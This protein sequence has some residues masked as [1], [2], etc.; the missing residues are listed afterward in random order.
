MLTSWTIM[1]IIRQ[2]W[3]E[4]LDSLA[5]S[6]SFINF[7]TNQNTSRLQHL[8]RAIANA[9]LCTR[10]KAGPYDEFFLSHM[11]KFFFNGFLST[12]NTCNSRE[13]WMKIFNLQSW[14]CFRRKKIYYIFD[15]FFFF[16]N[17][18]HKSKIKSLLKMT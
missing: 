9:R 15:K 5:S 16:W 8:R 11:V 1:N 10:L 7:T 18:F 12:F 13:M 14:K 3:N 4:F 6:N 17:T 2:I